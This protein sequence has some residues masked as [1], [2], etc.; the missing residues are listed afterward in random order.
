MSKR[1][2]V[3]PAILLAG[4]GAATTVVAQSGPPAQPPRAP[5]PPASGRAFKVGVV[6]I[7]VLFRDYKRKDLL[8]QQVNQQREKIKSD[9]DADQDNIVRMRRQ[10]DKGAFPPNSEPWLALRDEIKQAQYVY[11]LKSE[12]LQN[13]LKK[14]VEEMTLQILTELEATITSYGERNGYDLILKSDRDPE[15]D[16]GGQ[17]ELAAQFQERIFRAQISD[18]LYFA[19]AIDITEHVK[20]RLNDPDNLN[21]MEGL[22]REREQRRQLVQQQQPPADTPAA[23]TPP[24]PGH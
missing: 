22:A 19:D 15:D 10:L 3:L 9:L 23:P 11:E 21:R 13:Q 18:V 8:E 12:R 6:D 20:Q 14:R 17:G 2:S 1:H 4:V 16:D 24:G 5:Q 7:G